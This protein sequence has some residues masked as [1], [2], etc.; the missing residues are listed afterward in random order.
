MHI[1]PSEEKKS[2]FFYKSL[3]VIFFIVIFSV[4]CIFSYVNF[5][6]KLI[7]PLDIP[8]NTNSL[9]VYTSLGVENNEF[10]N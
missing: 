4:I 2:S 1:T 3:L 9:E 8:Q 10:A 5:S 7:A 6:S